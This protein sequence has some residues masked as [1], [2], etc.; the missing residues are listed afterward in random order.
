[1][2]QEQEKT[3]ALQ[4]YEGPAPAVGEEVVKPKK[5]PRAQVCINGQ[6]YVATVVEVT[7]MSLSIDHGSWFSSPRQ[8]GKSEAMRMATAKPAKVISVKNVTD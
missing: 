6:S 1:M 3:Q 8:S 5:M 4:R 7:L 2:A